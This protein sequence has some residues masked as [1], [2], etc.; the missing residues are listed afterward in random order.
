MKINSDGVFIVQTADRARFR[1][2]SVARSSWTGPSSTSTLVGEV[3]DALVAETMAARDGLLLAQE[4]GFS[5]VILDSDNS[6][7]VSSLKETEVDRSK[8]A[9][10]WHEI[11]ELSRGPEFGFAAAVREPLVKLRRP[12]HDFERW[13]W[14]YF[15]WPHDRLDEVNGRYTNELSW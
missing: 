11:R 4:M 1:S 8:I 2:S 10:L 15:V 14:D 6:M 3:E 9:G 7:L 12:E 13:D 5:H